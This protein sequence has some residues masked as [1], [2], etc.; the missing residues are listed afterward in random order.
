M[1]AVTTLSEINWIYVCGSIIAAI[2]AA[3]YISDAFEWLLVEKLGIETKSQR[4]KREEHELLIVTNREL[5]ELKKKH[6]ESV[7][8][9][10]RHDKLI[11]EDFT[12]FIDEI[13]NSILETQNQINQFTDNRVHDREQ[14]ISIQKELTDSIKSIVDNDK[15][16]DKKVEAL[17]IANKELLA[18][19][20]NQKYKQYIALRGIPA[21]E[22]DEFASLHK[23]YNAVGGNHHGDAKYNYIIEHL[24]VIPVETVLKY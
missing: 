5:S 14:S 11:K 23:A 20:I 10:I 12:G 24:P 13:K 3:K 18:D 22:V 7:V 21:D 1:D 9:A 4:K 16:R 8:Q 6:E 2:V 17:T 19:K 15:T